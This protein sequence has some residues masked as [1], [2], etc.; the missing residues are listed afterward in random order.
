M[1]I[2]KYKT[3][4]LGLCSCVLQL[5]EDGTPVPKHVGVLMLVM[6]S[7]L[8]S[9]IFGGYIDCKNMRGLII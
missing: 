6:N 9:A 2:Y 8:L 7:I 1:S 3:D 5:H 4:M